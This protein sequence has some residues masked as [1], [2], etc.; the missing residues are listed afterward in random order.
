MLAAGSAA[1]LVRVRRHTT[2]PGEP[3]PS[4]ASAS[5]AGSA[6]G[7]K[8]AQH[9][10]DHDHDHEHHGLFHS[11]SHDHGHSEGAEQIMEALRSGKLDRGTKITLLGELALGVSDS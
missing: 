11:H 3:G 6:S 5:A 10:H 9:D 2:K 7:S 1:S 8:V 4:T